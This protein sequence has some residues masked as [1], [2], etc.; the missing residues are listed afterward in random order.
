MPYTN[1]F[2]DPPSLTSELSREP[3]SVVV[4]K[5]SIAP[6]SKPTALDVP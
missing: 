2:A 1:R 3:L 4:S 6:F 5:L